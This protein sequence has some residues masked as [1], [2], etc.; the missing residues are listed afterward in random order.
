MTHLEE[1]RRRTDSPDRSAIPPGVRPETYAFLEAARASGADEAVDERRKRLI[2][3]YFSSRLNIT[4]LTS[5][6]QVSKS[7]VQRLLRSGLTTI[8]EH[9][10][11]DLQQIHPAERVVFL[12]EKS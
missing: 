2:N 10:P 1:Q 8:W 5:E 6:A 4:D 11:P 7:Q 12:K 9:L 3:M